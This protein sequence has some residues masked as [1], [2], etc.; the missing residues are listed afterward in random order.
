MTDTAQQVIV[1][2]SE[3]DSKQFR[4]RVLTA[5]GIV[6]GL[7][8]LLLFL[9]STASVLL[10]LFIGLLI[11]VALR[12]VSHWIASHTPL[13][14]QISLAVVVIGVVIL[15]ALLAL[16]IG[17]SLVTQID[18]LIQQLPTSLQQ[19][20]DMISKYSWGQ[21]LVDEMP[22]NLRWGQIVFGEQVNVFSRITGIVSTSISA[23][24]NFILL[25]FTALFLAIEPHTY[26]SGI[27]ELIPLGYRSRSKEVMLEV[28]N[29]LAQWLL[30]RAISM[31]AIGIMTTL[32]LKV[33]NVPLALSLGIIAG[34][35]AFI[36][37][38]GPFIAVVP[39]ALVGLLQSPQTAL[40]VI[41]LYLVI[42]SIDNYVLTPIVVKET[43]RMP[44]A[45]IILSQLIFGLLF[46]QLGLAVAAPFAAA[47]MTFVR[48][49]YVQDFLEHKAQNRS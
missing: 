49:T 48:L 36:P 32:G 25:L 15:I 11:G 47:A 31:V 45:L 21:W 9:Y 38:I 1:E 10:L 27:A 33:I 37:L 6:A 35:M 44:P 7:A 28:G 23:L 39:A 22:T 2:G 3:A 8:V 14:E 12:T 34:L 4:R 42:Q 5:V 19:I 43:I 24:G 13:S 30:T 20:D 29:T 40:W 18:Q 26:M 17:P 46:G 16:L 41:L